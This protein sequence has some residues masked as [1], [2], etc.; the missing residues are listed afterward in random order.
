MI[1]EWGRN[2][3]HIG[4]TIRHFFRAAFCTKYYVDFFL[5]KCDLTDSLCEYWCCPKVKEKIK[6]NEQH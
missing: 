4:K 5:E 6:K 2:I 1:Y 3:I